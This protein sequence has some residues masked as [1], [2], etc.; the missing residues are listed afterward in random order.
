MSAVTEAVRM[1]VACGSEPH[2]HSPMKCRPISLIWRMSDNWSWYQVVVV[3]RLTFRATCTQ[4]RRTACAGARKKEKKARVQKESCHFFVS[5]IF[6]S[7]RPKFITLSSGPRINNSFECVFHCIFGILSA[8][9]TCSC[10]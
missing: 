2:P 9:S 6:S 4:I 3:A 5:A 8:N 10:L 7:A 1:A